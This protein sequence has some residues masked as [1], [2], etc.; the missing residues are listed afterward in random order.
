MP[1]EALKELREWQRAQAS[2][3]DKAFRLASRALA[4]VVQL[5]GERLAAQSSLASAVAALEA[6]GVVRDQT[7][8]LLDVTPDELSR[9]LTAA[10]RNQP[11]TSGR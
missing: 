9:L 4:R 11:P 7:A 5:E 3:Q 10:R 2:E 1:S 8:A 6:S